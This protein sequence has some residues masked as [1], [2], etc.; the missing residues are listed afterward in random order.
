MDGCKGRSHTRHYLS[1]NSGAIIVGN[2]RIEAHLIEAPSRDGFLY[3]AAQHTISTSDDAGNS[4]ICALFADPNEPIISLAGHPE[5]ETLFVGTRKG[6]YVSTDRALNFSRFVSC[7][8]IPVT[9]L[10][11]DHGYLYAATFGR[12]LW[13]A[14]LCD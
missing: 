10:F 7:C 9:G 14:A 2:G 3:A 6:V 1:R 4:C 13:R 5:N 11:L 12:G 8:P